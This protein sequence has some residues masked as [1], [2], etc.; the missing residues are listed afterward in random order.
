MF[1]SLEP[2]KAHMVRPSVCSV[3][4]SI[5]LAGQFVMQSTVDKSSDNLECRLAALDNEVGNAASFSALGKGAVHCLDDVAAHTEVAQAALGL[6]SDHPFLWRGG[7][8]EAH[9]LQ[10]LKTT[11]HQAPDLGIGLT[12]ILRAKIDRACLIGHQPDLS[13][14]PRPSFRRDF[15]LERIADLV[16]RLWTEFDGDQF[17]GASAQ[18]LADVVAGDHEIRSFLIYSPNEKTNVRVVGV[19]MID[20][21]P[22]EARTKVDF[23]L[24]GEI[25]GKGLQV[26]HVAGVLG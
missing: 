24:S 26:G 5:G 7:C 9:L 4:Q 2:S 20:S 1:E 12:G 17:L 19:P 23:H 25:A 13:V 6:E 18:A 3:D 16:L 15:P 11:D 21:H 10:V 22:I 8:G 14:E